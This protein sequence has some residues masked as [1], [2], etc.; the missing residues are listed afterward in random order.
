MG[1]A[2]ENVLPR[3]SVTVGI[4][5]NFFNKEFLLYSLDEV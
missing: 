3:V 4:V 5:H 1:S 2:Q